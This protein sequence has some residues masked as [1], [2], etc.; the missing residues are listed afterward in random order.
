MRYHLKESALEFARTSYP[1]L[2]HWMNIVC[3]YHYAPRFVDQF[4]PKLTAGYK[5]IN[6]DLKRP[7]KG[8]TI[9]IH[10]FIHSFKID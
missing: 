10:D 8:V 9:K 4:D 6:D 3:S 7:I 1:P 2:P 5:I